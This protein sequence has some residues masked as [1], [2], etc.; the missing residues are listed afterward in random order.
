MLQES[1]SVI[2]KEGSI[3]WFSCGV[4]GG[5]HKLANQCRVLSVRQLLSH[6]P[7]NALHHSSCFFLA[8]PG[9][10]E[11]QATNYEQQEAKLYS[12]VGL[13]FAHTYLGNCPSNSN[14]LAATW[15]RFQNSENLTSKS[16][17]R[18]WKT[19]KNQKND[20]FNTTKP[21]MLLCDY[22]VYHNIYSIFNRK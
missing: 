20:R 9:R 6:V 15:R 19:S 14:S 18:H 22:R 5:S 7:T 8:S 10:N 1:V 4:H 11:Q 16:V 2:G 13:L 12:I 21:P 17:N 3:Y